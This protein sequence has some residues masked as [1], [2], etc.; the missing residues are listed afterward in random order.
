MIA[1]LASCIVSSSF[2]LAQ[3]SPGSAAPPPAAQQKPTPEPVAGKTLAVDATEITDA[4][5]AEFIARIHGGEAAEVIR[6]LEHHPLVKKA[7]NRRAEIVLGTAFYFAGRMREASLLATK[8]KNATS[9]DPVQL[10][11]VGYAF[12]GNDDFDTAE[13]YFRL[14]QQW[15]PG[16]VE[17]RFNE[18]RSRALQRPGSQTLLEVKAFEADA[19]KLPKDMYMKVVADLSLRIAREHIRLDSVG[20]ETYALLKDAIARRPGDLDAYELLASLYIESENF[21]AAAPI[22][23]EMERRFD[24]QLWVVV[25]LKARA[26]EK[27]GDPKQALTLGQDA[28]TLSDRKHLPSLLL[29]GR[30][31][32]ALDRFDDARRPLDDALQVAPGNYDA[33]TLFARY[34]YVRASTA[35]DGEAR[36][37]FMSQAEMA[38]RR[39]IGINGN[40]SQVFAVLQDVYTLW[41]KP[42]EV[43]LAAVR[44]DLERTRLIEQQAA[45][46]RA[47]TKAAQKPR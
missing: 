29:V 33:W 40:D 43:E 34:L 15:A 21:D 6:E 14:A 19:A 16:D 8:H 10:K 44:Q 5:V 39:A 24:D 38:A 47:A 45:A 3:G 28:I 32:M 42:K 35:T 7:W 27:R 31:A 11:F 41:G 22:L 46:K 37:D 18:V 26:L 9:R 1:L 4:Q 2:V 13:K 17:A 30:L 20:E 23:D 25:F 36:R 12:L